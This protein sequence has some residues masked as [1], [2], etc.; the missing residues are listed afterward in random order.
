MKQLSSSLKE[1]TILQY[2]TNHSSYK[3]QT[4]FLQQMRPEEHHIIA[5]QEPWINPRTRKT[6]THPGYYTILPDDHCPRTAIY[7]TKEIA[8]TS[9]EAICHSG[10]LATLKLKTEDLIIHIHNCYNPHRPYTDQG[11]G[12][13]P[14]I[15]KAIQ[16]SEG[17]EHILLGD[18]NL[19]HPKWG[20]NLIQTQHKAAD[21]FIEII[22]EKRLHLLTEPGAITWE[23]SRSC[24][25]LDLTFSTELLRESVTKCRIREDLETGSDHKPIQTTFQTIRTIKESQQARLQW[26]KA[27]WEAIR[28]SLQERLDTLTLDP[29]ETTEEID[30]TIQQT[31][32]I[33]QHT[34]E[35]RVPK[36][37]P[38]RF[39]KITWTEESQRL[40]KQ[41][42]K[43]RRIWGQD[44]TEASLQAYLTS[45][46]AKGKQIR[47]DTNLAWRR[48]ITEGTGKENKIWKLAR[49]AREKADQQ[50]T[51]PQFPAMTNSQGEEVTTYK[52]KADI[53]AAHFFP[54]PKPA[55]LSDLLRAR[56]P[57]PF[58]VSPEVTEEEILGILKRLPPNKAP[59][60]D[61][62]PNTFL[63]ACRHTLAPT[64][65]RLFTACLQKQHHP[66]PFK[67]SITV[68][69]RKPQKPDYTKA[70]A[71]RPIALLNTLAKVLEAVAARRIS[72]E[73]EQRKLLPD[74]QMGARPGRSTLSAIEFVTEQVHTI[75]GNNPRMV[76]SMLCLDISG[77]FDNVSH[78]RLIHNLKMKGFPP[79]ITG[80]VQSFLKD[81][82]TCL[83]LGDYKDQARPQP[84]GIPQGSTLSPIL[85]LLFASTLLPMLEEGPT[86]AL[87]F[88]DDTNILTFRKTTEENCRRLE[89]AHA[90][91]LRWA[92]Q[93][94]AAFAPQKYQLIHFTRSRKRHNL[95]ATVDIQ[96]FQAGP[97]PSLRL[98]G[99]WVDT[100]LQW[101]PHIKK[102]AEKGQNQMQSLQRL[103]KSTWGATFQKARHLYTAVVRPGI[104]YGCPIWT[105]PAKDRGSYS[106]Q[107]TAL[108][109]IQNQALRHIT[110]AYKSVP[111]AVLQNEADIPPLALYTQELARQHA[112][113]TQD[114]LVTQYIKEKCN[115][116]AQ[117][118]KKGRNRIIRAQTGITM[119][120]RWIKLIETQR[121]QEHLDIRRKEKKDRWL[122]KQWD[123]RWEQERQRKQQAQPEQ[124]IPA[125]WTTLRQGG[126][127][128]LHKGWTRPQSTMATLI[129]TEHIGLGAYLTKR[130]VPGARPECTCGYRTQTVKHILIFCPEKQE[131]RER[132]LREAGTSNWKD[133]A[134]TKRGLTAAARWMI[135]EAVLDQFS[136]AR[137]EEQERERRETDG[138]DLVRG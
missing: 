18:F 15:Q 132:L 131:A 39:A 111:E 95:Q 101:G 109:K 104:T 12:T 38:S 89:A 13:I 94:G 42:R 82:T 29:L 53:L 41:T 47:R 63:K 48:L 99:V 35:Q 130:R 92:A 64:L 21:T 66:N 84:T 71:Y 40:V 2:N 118:C 28:I 67:H 128:R 32:E 133:L 50:T 7:I 103:C 119:K 98:L 46:K 80:F 16:E 17:V 5:I 55:D 113:K 91:C 4:P 73:A 23:T 1:I 97:V 60:P 123:K 93:H 3:I 56:Y 70:G 45:S 138:R 43:M 102:A 81:R 33:I 6:V 107:I 58:P 79:T 61:R 129:R 34:I 30:R 62:I 134:N 74:S 124:E 125:V 110:G 87:G 76:A 85:F 122:Q 75:W 24:Q 65:A 135:Q 120:E 116:V 88:V 108:E 137:D 10:D 31:Q 96:G 22:K 117:I 36:A 20:G 77:A 25:T 100:K 44:R 127:L 9:W 49:W 86:T 57:D 59:G 114:L 105:Q 37:K 14:L 52:G 115:Q 106:R 112:Q 51:L 126:G 78:Q 136:L 54:E 90:K 19:H 11:L 69:L 72:K 8:T 121:S 27:D 68:V 83:K 26:K